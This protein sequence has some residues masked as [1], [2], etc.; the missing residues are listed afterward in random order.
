MKFKIPNRCRGVILLNPSVWVH[1]C[2][3]FSSEIPFI[4]VIHGI[5]SN[6]LFFQLNDGRLSIIA[7]NALLALYWTL[8]CNALIWKTTDGINRVRRSNSLPFLFIIGKALIC[9][10]FIR[11]W[12][13]LCYIHSTVATCNWGNESFSIE[14][15]TIFRGFC[16]IIAIITPRVLNGQIVLARRLWNWIIRCCLNTT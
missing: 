12:I 1:G 10:I 7:W 16:I 5:I 9:F 8:F 6:I 15:A 14:V 11:I 13:S 3:N 2:F 4:E